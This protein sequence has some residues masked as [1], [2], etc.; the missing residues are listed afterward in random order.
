MLGGAGGQLSLLPFSKDLL[1]YGKNVYDV[2]SI[3]TLPPL[4]SVWSGIPVFIPRTSS[5]LYTL[6]EMTITQINT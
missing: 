6:S 3:G 5:T 1:F 4:P 2:P